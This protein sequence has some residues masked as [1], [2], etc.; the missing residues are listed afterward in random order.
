M[1]T[2][3]GSL[4]RSAF[5]LVETIIALFVLTLLALAL[6][7]T[8][9]Y[10]GYMAEGNLYEATALTVAS[11]IIE[12]VKGTSYDNL[13]NPPVRNGN[14]SLELVAG[15]GESSFL[16]LGAFND[17]DVPLVSPQNGTGG[18]V[19]QLR[20]RPSLTAMAGG[21]G[22]WIEV[23]YEFDQPGTNRLQTRVLRNARS[24]VPTN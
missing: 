12:Q 22:Y 9:I 10:T 18:K 6:T 17:L 14:P 24:A 1:K 3:A 7:K 20:V 21:S 5:S 4:R 19:M 23:E 15:S 13:R 8:L 2:S 16:T 11:S